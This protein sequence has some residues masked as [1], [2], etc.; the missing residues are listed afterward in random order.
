MRCDDEQG[1]DAR[2]LRPRRDREGT[3][4]VRPL[5]NSD[6]RISARR[7]SSHLRMGHHNEREEMETRNGF[8]MTNTRARMRWEACREIA[9]TGGWAAAVRAM[10]LGM[11]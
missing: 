10:V 1:R 9:R 2:V 8:E 5:W 3:S 11:A 4:R 7:A 6:A